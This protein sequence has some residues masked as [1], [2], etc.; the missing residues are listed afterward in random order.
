MRWPWESSA[1]WPL[2][3]KN[4]H[5]VSLSLQACRVH[6]KMHENTSRWKTHPD[7]ISHD[8][9]EHKLLFSEEL[10]LVTVYFEN[11]GSAW[12][13]IRVWLQIKASKAK[14]TETDHNPWTRNVW[15]I[16]KV[17]NCNFEKANK[18]KWNIRPGNLEKNPKIP[19]KIF[20]LRRNTKLIPV[21]GMC[22][23]G[24][25]ST[26]A[27]GVRVFAIDP[28]LLL[29]PRGVSS[30]FYLEQSKPQQQ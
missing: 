30:G 11:L 27:S 5:L 24:R 22:D 6:T 23:S 14:L 7:R 15:Q 3:W 1:K 21:E 25:F 2:H 13:R 19:P 9:S 10:A 28:D 26:D 8:K 20:K 17:D 4:A 29:D 12:Y 16:C 18:S